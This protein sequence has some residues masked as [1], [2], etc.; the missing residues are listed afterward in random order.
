MT[1]K[2]KFTRVSKFKNIIESIKD[3]L[4][5]INIYVTT[6]GFRISAM[7][8]CHVSIIKCIIDSTMFEE[9]HCEKD[10]CIGLSIQNLYKILKCMDNNDSLTLQS[11]E[12]HLV[13]SSQAFRP[14]YIQNQD[15]LNLN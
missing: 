10:S 13:I 2:A 9:F 1:F 14:N 11:T 3:L 4:T 6:D 7:D 8:S 5:D 15:I 12:T